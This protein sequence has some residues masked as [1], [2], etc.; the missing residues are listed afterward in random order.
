MAK[1]WHE[2]TKVEHLGGSKIRWTC[3]RGH[4]TIET[5]TV[6]PKGFKRPMH[7]GMVAKMCRYWSNRVTYKCRKCE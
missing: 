7:S 1:I 6:G 5:L 2:G 3:P 4:V